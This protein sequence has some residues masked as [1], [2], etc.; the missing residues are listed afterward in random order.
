MIFFKTVRKLKYT[1]NLNLFISLLP[2]HYKKMR[3][4][5]I[6]AGMC[7]CMKVSTIL[8]VNY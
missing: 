6:G 4:M 7:S 3:G 1:F 5:F 2:D 8:P